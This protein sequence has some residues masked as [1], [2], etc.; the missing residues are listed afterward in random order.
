MG[1]TLQVRPGATVRLKVQVTVPA[2]NNSP[3]SFTNPLLAQVGIGQPLNEPSIDHIDLITGSVTGV[4][5]PGAPGYAVP[6]AANV[7]GAAVVYN[8]T[9]QIAQQLMAEDAKK[10]VLA[11]GS[12]RLSWQTSIVAGNT[13]FYIRARGTNIPVATPNVT[14]SAGNPLLD[15]NNAKVACTDPACPAHLDTV[16][17]EKRV[18]YD[19]A[20]YSNLWFYANPI[21]VRP[22][23]SPKLM[24]ERNA[25]LAAKLGG[26]DHSRGHDD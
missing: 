10:K 5:E 14:D 18:T 7:A 19:V 21:F 26:D 12:V 8:P 22:A 6:N 4:I 25:E 23:G 11:D 20:A 16:N 2:K 9:A 1:G 15:T 17:G 24:V 3:Y 13:P